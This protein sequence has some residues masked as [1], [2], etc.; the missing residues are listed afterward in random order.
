MELEVLVGLSHPNICAYL[1]AVARFPPDK[2]M[3]VVCV[4]VERERER[5]RERKREKEIFSASV[6][7]RGMGRDTLGKEGWFGVDSQQST[8][9]SQLSTVNSHHQQL[10]VDS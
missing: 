7:G 5:E 10:T 8:A 6:C 1:G 2:D 4:R 3:E 9:N